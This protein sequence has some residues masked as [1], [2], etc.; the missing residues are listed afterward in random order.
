MQIP[1]G[2][3]TMGWFSKPNHKYREGQAI[4]WRRGTM[5]AGGVVVKFRG[6]LM[7]V[8]IRESSCPTL[9]KGNAYWFEIDDRD[10]SA[11]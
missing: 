9:V 2:R 1:K 3:E 5:R 8:D 6:D 10:W 7:Y 4:I 11:E